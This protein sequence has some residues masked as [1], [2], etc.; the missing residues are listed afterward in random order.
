M[1][2]G[3]AALAEDFPE[4]SL[5]ETVLARFDEF[6]QDHHGIVLERQVD[7]TKNFGRLATA[8]ARKLGGVYPTLKHSA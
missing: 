8:T 5:L 6:V 4:D 3:S 7:A 1:Q 2:L